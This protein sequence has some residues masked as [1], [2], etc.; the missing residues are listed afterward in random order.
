LGE[1]GE[2]VVEII[3]KA[4]HAAE[5]QE[6][7]DV[8]GEEPEAW[9]VCEHKGAYRVSAHYVLDALREAGYVVVYGPQWIMDPNPSK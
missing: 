5:G 4:L 8:F 3:A 7:K 9:E 1:K 2:D 6:I